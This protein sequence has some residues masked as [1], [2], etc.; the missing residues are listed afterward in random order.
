MMTKNKQTNIQRMI[1]QC[2]TK[3]GSMIH[4]FILTVDSYKMFAKIKTD[5][6]WMNDE[7]KMK[8]KRKKRYLIRLWPEMCKNNNNNKKF[9][10]TTTRR[11]TKIYNLYSTTKFVFSFSLKY[12]KKVWEWKEWIIETELKKKKKIQNTL[13]FIIEKEL[14]I[15]T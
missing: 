7:N 6:F 8:T 15:I 12:P 14:R 3:R 11:K 10:K 2:D 13:L 4:S 1:C 9:T 5:T